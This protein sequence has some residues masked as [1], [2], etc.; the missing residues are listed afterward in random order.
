MAVT[1]TRGL[2]R[3]Y[4]VAQCAWA[5]AVL[6]F[7]YGYEPW[8]RGV[9]G[10]KQLENYDSRIS[11]RKVCEDYAN[12]QTEEARKKAPRPV[13]KTRTPHDP[14]NVE[15]LQEFLDEVEQVWEPLVR[16]CMDKQEKA[17]TAD[18]VQLTYWNLS[19]HNLKTGLWWH[20]RSWSARLVLLVVLVPAM[21][22]AALRGTTWVWLWIIAGF[23]H[24][25][26]P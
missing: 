13:K 20:G 17:R 23:R 6:G 1:V 25:P 2:K 11:D 22:Y 4:I 10:R 14:A 8:S 21:V 24:Q 15:G 19:Q 9:E 7:A 26:E 5:V 12:W 16:Q 18:L 3:L